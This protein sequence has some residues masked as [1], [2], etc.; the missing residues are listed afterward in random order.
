MLALPL[1]RLD[2]AE[3]G[4]PAVHIVS[5]EQEGPFIG[6]VLAGLNLVAPE[7][8]GPFGTI[9][10]VPVGNALVY[11]ALDT[12]AG[13]RGDIAKLALFAIRFA[14]EHQG[15][16]FL[17]L[18]IWRRRD[19]RT[20]IVGFR[21]AGPESIEESYDPGFAGVLAA[22]DPLQLLAVP[23]W[24]QGVLDGEA[25]TRFAG[26]V[27]ATRD[28]S[29]ADVGVLGSAWSLPGLAVQCETAPFEQWPSL[30][31]AYLESIKADE[32]AARTIVREAAT[33]P[34]AV[35]DHLVTWLD[36]PKAATD[37][38]VARPLGETGLV[39]ILG[40]YASG[41]AVPLPA[42]S[43][44]TVGEADELLAIGREAIRRSL[45]VGPLPSPLLSGVAR[46]VT[47]DPTPTAAV[48]HLQTWLPEIV[49]PYGALVAVGS[50][51]RLVV[52]PIEDASV[53][54]DLPTLL[55]LASGATV[56]APWPIPPTVFWVGPGQ[57]EA[58]RVVTTGRRDLR[59]RRDM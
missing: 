49:G 33:D 1:T 17:K 29:P 25:F 45:V 55:G 10:G 7:S 12:A 52:L 21:F 15:D 4:S 54:L 23:G 37:T 48:P 11:R 34:A 44:A 59:G 27:S 26:C 51:D 56:R 9:V 14:Q 32:D 57:L 3:Q 40:V 39:E 19:G 42:E 30:V 8:V 50:A 20:R 35:R 18:P 2:W 47:G 22:L 28:V 43:A 36:G 38:S 6:A 5:L 53:A 46:W 41:L 58:F 31:E 13:L 24:A 16:G